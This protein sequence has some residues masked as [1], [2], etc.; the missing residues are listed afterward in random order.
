MA[1]VICYKTNKPT[2]YNKGTVYET[3]CDT[4]IAYYTFKTVDEAQKEVDEINRT[5]PERLWNGELAR[6]DER[7]YFV[8]EQVEMY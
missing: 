1:T 5:K 7:T 3:S 8:S 6:C 2:I 4:F